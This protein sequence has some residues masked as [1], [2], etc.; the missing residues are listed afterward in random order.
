MHLTARTRKAAGSFELYTE[1]VSTSTRWEARFAL[2]G[3]PLCMR[4]NIQMERVALPATSQNG[5]SI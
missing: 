5:V 4:L 1:N 3:A 2:V